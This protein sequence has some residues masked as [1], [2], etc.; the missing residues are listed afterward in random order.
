MQRE[1][2]CSFCQVVM[3]PYFLT[4][5]LHNSNLLARFLHIDFSRPY[6]LSFCMS[7]GP[8]L[9]LSFSIT[10]RIQRCYAFDAFGQSADS[11]S[12]SSPCIAFCCPPPSLCLSN[13]TA[14]L[15]TCDAV[16]LDCHIDSS[17]KSIL[18]IDFFE[19]LPFHSRVQAP[20]PSPSRTGQSHFRSINR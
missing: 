6:S 7:N 17:L 20:P 14:A 11:Q 18:F 5:P 4:A 16:S 19:I 10:L 12:A 2:Y 15:Q 13:P 1:G 3:P 8:S 9:L